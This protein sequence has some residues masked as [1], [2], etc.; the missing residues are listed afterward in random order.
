MLTCNVLLSGWQQRALMNCW[1]ISMSVILY[2]HCHKLYHSN[3]FFSVTFWYYFSILILGLHFSIIQLMI[4]T[5]HFLTALLIYFPI[6]VAKVTSFFVVNKEFL[7]RS[8]WVISTITNI[9]FAVL[10]SLL[11]I[12]LLYLTLC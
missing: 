6:N 11:C 5:H 3:L 2:L 10:V 7:L 8:K 12:I 4:C 9:I 1:S